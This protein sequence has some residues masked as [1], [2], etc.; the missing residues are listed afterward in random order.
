MNKNKKIKLNIGCGG[1]PLD[2]YINIDSDNLQVLKTRYPN[3]TFSEGIEIH[4]YDIFNLPFDG[5][6]V[7]EIRADS[8]IEHLSFIEEP[9]FFNEIKRVL[10]PGGIFEFSTTNFEEIAKLWLAA[11]DEWKEFYRNDSEAIKSQHWFGQYSYSTENRWGYLSAMIFGS[12][13]GEGQFHKNCYTIPKIKA[14]LKHLNFEEIKITQSLW[15]SDRDPMINVI[16]KNVGLCYD[17][18]G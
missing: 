17:H 10:K 13:N 1:R 4:D 6:I 7:D 5:G 2:G 11:K 15:K 18:I 8:L 14:I 3:Q 16:A 12:Q 9:K